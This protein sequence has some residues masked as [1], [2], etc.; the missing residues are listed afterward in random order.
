MTRIFLLG[1]MGAGK[2][3]LGRAL[4]AALGLQFIDLDCYIEERF[5]KTIS[6]IFAEKGEDEFRN[7]ER[8]MLHEAGE[9]EDVIISTGG[10]TPCFFDNVEYMNSQGTTVFLD[11]PVERLFIR[12]SIARHKRPLIKEKNDE[13]LRTF[14]AEQLGKRLPHYSKATHTFRADK[15]EDKRQIDM[16]VETFRRQLGI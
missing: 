9:F 3:T 10:G 6:Q 7:I 5:R 14:I 8:R 13:E 12:L 2:T 11:V 4:A 15:L 16:S 1:Y